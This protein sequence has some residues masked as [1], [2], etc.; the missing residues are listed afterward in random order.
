MTERFDMPVRSRVLMGS[1]ALVV[2]AGCAS[3]TPAPVR[4]GTSSAGGAG[5]VATA[6]PG[7]YI[8]RPGDTLFGIGRMHNRNV[9]DLV[10]W[11]NLANPHQI[12]VGQRLRIAPPAGGSGGGNVQVMPVATAGAAVPAARSGGAPTR[13]EP[14]GGTQTYNDQ[15]WNQ[16]NQ[17][18]P[19]AQ[20]PVAVATAPATLPPTTP[21]AQGN[22]NS[23]WLWPA[24]GRILA[25]FNES[26]NK[27]LDIA[28]NLGDPVVASAAGKVVYAGSGLRGYGKLVIIKHDDEYLT[29]YGHNRELLVKEGDS[30]A[31]GQR[32]AELGNTD[33]SSPRLH[34]ELRKQGRPVD[35]M[36]Y[37]PP[38]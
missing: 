30:V 26:T 18:S 19:P 9:N 16:A 22:V 12:T 28:G 20:P 32:I 27:G 3:S 11:N 7:E 31:R 21:P 2:L 34:F 24:S 37:L 1:L 8:V 10:M 25:N 33:A 29:A 38:R 17:P 23:K 5:Q 13:Q 14:R 36:G 6:G 35:P 4:Q 15:A